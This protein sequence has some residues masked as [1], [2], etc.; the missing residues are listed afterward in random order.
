M[1]S[2]DNWFNFLAC[3]NP[4]RNHF[5]TFRF[6]ESPLCFRRSLNFYS[7]WFC[8]NLGVNQ[9]FYGG[10]KNFNLAVVQQPILNSLFVGKNQK[11]QLILFCNW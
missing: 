2:G 11:G 3:Y 9:N 5:E 6:L 7:S 10:Y 8:F 1:D 4:S